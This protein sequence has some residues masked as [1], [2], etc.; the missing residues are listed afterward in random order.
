[1]GTSTEERLS[2]VSSLLM[3]ELTINTVVSY[4]GVSGGGGGGGRE[5]TGRL[6]PLLLMP[7]LTINT[8]VSY[9]GVLGG[10]GGGEG[11]NGST[12]SSPTDARAHDKYCSLVPRRLGGGGGGGGREG[13]G[14]LYPLLLM[15]ELTINTVVSYP[16]VSGGGE[17]GGRERVDCI[18]S[19]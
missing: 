9:P 14:R 12:V 3:P 17:G 15:P 4:P 5:G 11:G 2:T 13:T 8:V 19:Y 1:M 7:E 16:G 18:L 10:G 6:Y